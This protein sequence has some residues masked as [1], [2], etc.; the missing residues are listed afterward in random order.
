[1][2]IKERFLNNKGYST[3]EMSYV[4]TIVIFLC[5]AIIFLFVNVL[6]DGMIFGDCYSELY[7]YKTGDESKYDVEVQNYQIEIS[8]DQGK[9]SEDY[10][11]LIY[12]YSVPD[13]VFKT[14]YETCSMRLRRWQLYGDV[15]S[16]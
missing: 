5:I 3:V 15:F 16:E 10:E 12:N 7:T 13:Y 2:K 8:P 6:Q 1:M 4:M 14:E 11:G 9:N